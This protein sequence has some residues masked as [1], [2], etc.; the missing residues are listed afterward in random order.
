MWEFNDYK[1]M[2]GSDMVVFSNAQHPKFSMQLHEV[3]H[4]VGAVPTHQC[5]PCR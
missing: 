5:A 3:D 2:L 1:L 4:E